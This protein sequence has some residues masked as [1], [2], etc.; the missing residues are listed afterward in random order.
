MVVKKKKGNKAP[1]KDGAE[2]PA[3]D[4][5][6]DFV[7]EELPSK[8]KANDGAQDGQP[9]E[10]KKKQRMTAEDWKKKKEE[11]KAQRKQHIKEVLAAKPQREKKDLVATAPLECQ[12]WLYANPLDISLKTLR[13][14]VPGLSTIFWLKH[15]GG[16]ASFETEGAWKHALQLKEVSVHG[17][18]TRIDEYEKDGEKHVLANAQQDD[19][20]GQTVASDDNENKVDDKK[21]QNLKEMRLETVAKLPRE[22]FQERLKMGVTNAQM[23]QLLKIR[24]QYFDILPKEENLG[25]NIPTKGQRPEDGH[26]R[27]AGKR[28]AFLSNRPTFIA[29]QALKQRIDGI[30][31]VQWVQ[32]KQSKQFRHSGF[33]G[34]RVSFKS[35][36]YADRALQTMRYNCHGSE[37]YVRGRPKSTSEDEAFP[38]PVEG[39]GE[40]KPL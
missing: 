3:G 4:P 38:G 22:Q 29:T 16:Y 13:Q 18:I 36:E 40:F 39:E 5:N 10:K 37:V 7:F 2:K 8:R 21:K 6:E 24:S 19:T 30:E 27:H 28:K 15:G 11:K 9:P 26:S 17:S 31:A 23:S 1:T 25:Y 35:A 12:A 20:A 33:E 32:A 34:A 14:Y